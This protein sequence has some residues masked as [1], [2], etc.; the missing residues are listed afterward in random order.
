MGFART[1]GQPTRSL[2]STSSAPKYEWVL[3]ADIEACFDS[4]DHTALLER[5]RSRIGDKR[6]L[7][8]VKAF[9]KA[10]IL[11]ELG[12]E[13]ETIAGTPQGG[14]LS[15]LLA[16]IALSVLDEHYV[17][18][19][20]PTWGLRN[21]RR[22]RGHATWRLV[23]YAD[24]FVVMVNGTRAHTEALRTEIASV[25]APMGL[26]LSEAKTQVVHLDE[27]FDFLGW[28]I[29]RHRKRGTDRYYVYTY[30][31]KK[32]LAS[33]VGKVRALTHKDAHRSLK[34]LLLQL[35]PVLR[36]WAFYFRQGVSQSVFQYLRAFSWRRV[37][38][39]MKKLHKGL[40]WKKLLRR[41]F[42]GSTKWEVVADGIVLFDPASIP[43]KRYRYRGANIPTPWQP[44][45]A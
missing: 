39:W 8:L 28:R 26:R 9:L 10:G 12:R 22:K 41:A 44:S 34:A 40:S 14:I 20:P 6:V 13:E 25:L 17:K 3:D 18:N 35:N 23:R 36:G 29:Q 11:T 24:D 43:S 7:S 4:I 37:A 33:V 1:V 2:R 32:S 21:G 5:V 16:N 15:P 42:P 31:S 30:P 38:I 45:V 27:G 19:W